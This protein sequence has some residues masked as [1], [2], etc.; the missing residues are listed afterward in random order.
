MHECSDGF[1]G[2][3]WRRTNLNSSQEEYL[4]PIGRALEN[5]D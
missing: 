5:R 1:E 4:R 3:T 2:T